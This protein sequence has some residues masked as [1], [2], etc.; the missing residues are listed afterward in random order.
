MMD[1]RLNAAERRVKQT[2]GN[3][4]LTHG[5]DAY[6]KPELNRRRRE[7]GKALCRQGLTELTEKAPAK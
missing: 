1:K 7:L 3:C 6:E 4:H 5:A 2:R